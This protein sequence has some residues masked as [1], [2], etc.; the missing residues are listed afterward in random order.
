MRPVQQAL[1]TPE[2]LAA[3]PAAR[4]IDVRWYLSG[5][6][7]RDAYDRGH[8][9]GAVF[10]DID[11]ELSGDPT[12]GPGRHPLPSPPQFEMQMNRAGVGPGTDVVIYDDAG[13]AIAARLW[14]LLR[15]FGHRGGA[16][17]LDGGIDRWIAEGRPLETAAPQPDRPDP[18]FRADPARLSRRIVSAQT[19]S[20]A[21]RDPRALVLDARAPER[22]RGDVEPVDARPGHIPGAKS[23]PFAG[24]LAGGRFKSP[25]ELRARFAALGAEDADRVIAYC[26]SG[27]TAC[28]D[29]LAL[30]L[31]GF[32]DDKLALYEGSWSDWARHS[33]LP[34]KRGQD[35]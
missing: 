31:A 9:P 35:P 15:L 19:V 13:G 34:A 22:Y 33:N 17:V 29:L 25:A 1:V 18:P 30:H 28:H 32:P 16:A 21:A 23:A 11:G 3:N 8:I 6:R 27:V 14:F 10:L 20:A 24:N 5:K 12:R 4:V 7:G 26:G 2:Q